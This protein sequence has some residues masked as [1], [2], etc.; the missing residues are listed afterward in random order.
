MRFQW[1]T[2]MVLAGA[3]GLSAHGEVSTTTA[4]MQKLSLDGVIDQDNDDT[5]AFTPDGNTVFFDHSE[6][7]HKTIMIAHK[8]HGRWSRAQVAS[9][10]GKWFDQD[11]VVSPDGRYMLF[12]S[13]RPISV[14]GE[15]LVQTY[16]S[17]TDAPGSNLWCVDRRGKGWGEPRWIGAH[18][19]N[20]V[21]VDFASIAG[22]GTLY[23]MRWDSKNRNMELWRARYNGGEYGSPE[24]VALGDPS[25]SI[26][27]PAVAKDQS[28]IVFDYGKVTGGLG[29]LSIAFRRGE[30][31]SA[32]IDMG[33]RVNAD[34]PWGP[35]LSPDG[36]TVYVTGHSGIWQLNIDPWLD[37]SSVTFAPGN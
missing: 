26:H 28:F 15:P 33:D 5:L 31:W 23:F 30:G 3:M 19:N 20:D 36:H 17:K 22:D 13:D 29:R 27:D 18:I 32:P 34:V 6:G 25:V 14:G 16:F 11:P 2:P 24:R 21:F 35:H 4:A 1:I 37:T 12:N 9:F 8:A 10:S 7:Q